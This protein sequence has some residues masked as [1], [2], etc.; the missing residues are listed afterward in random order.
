L[1]IPERGHTADSPNSPRN[2][3]KLYVS[4]KIRQYISAISGIDS[5]IPQARRND[6]EGGGN[7]GIQADVPRMHQVMSAAPVLVH[8][9]DYLVNVLSYSFLNEIRNEPTVKS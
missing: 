5:T 7:S 6:R 9:V 2:I 8:S 3:Q 4:N 1:P